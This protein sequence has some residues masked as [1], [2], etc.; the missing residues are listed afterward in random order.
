MR[1]AT[2]FGNAVRKLIVENDDAL[3]E[4]WL[5]EEGGFDADPGA[6]RE[7]AAFVQDATFLK[8]HNSSAVLKFL[9]FDYATMDPA[10]RE[11]V[12]KE[13][14][15]LLSRAYAEFEDWMSWYLICDMLGRY[16]ANDLALSTLIRLK[17]TAQDQPRSLVPM[18]LGLLVREASDRETSQLAL[19]ELK[20][21]L[22]DPAEEVRA[23]AV[24]ALKQ[25][26]NNAS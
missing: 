14:V 26:R 13:I 4:E 24:L 23:E 25:V 5:L 19:S 12:E 18:G 2:R 8:A 17:G 3:L 1:Q 9:G 20:S 22:N 6:L 10:S 15:P 21:L 11:Y 7:L 16:L